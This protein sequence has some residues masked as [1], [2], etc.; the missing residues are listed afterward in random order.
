MTERPTR[1]RLF[2]LRRDTD[3]TGYSGTGDVAD[4]VEWP[5]GTVSMRW[6]GKVR[7]FQNA[8]RLADIADIHGH[9]GATRI[10]EDCF[11]RLAD[12]DP[13]LATAVQA[14]I[15]SGHQAEAR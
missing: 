5:D 13:E 8:D 15:S 6:R 3:V 1:P 2:I 10:V 4:I 7:T 14:A 12:L 9:D 11:V